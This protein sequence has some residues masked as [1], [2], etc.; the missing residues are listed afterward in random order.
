MCICM[1]ALCDVIQ[2]I[3]D[4]GGGAARRVSHGGHADR[5]RAAPEADGARALLRASK[6]HR[7]RHQERH[8]GMGVACVWDDIGGVG[9]SFRTGRAHVVVVV[10]GCARFAVIKVIHVHVQCC[11]VFDVAA[12]N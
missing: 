10:V 5:A 3:Q 1:F 11:R 6:D 2:S 12:H 8:E 7:R 9:V 4:G